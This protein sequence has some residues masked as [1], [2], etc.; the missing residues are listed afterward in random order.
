MGDIMCTPCD[1]VT[2]VWVI[3][4]AH[5]VTRSHMWVICAHHVTNI[6][7][8]PCALDSLLVQ[9]IFFD[10]EG[11][12]VPTDRQTETDRQRQTDTDTQTDRETD[13]HRQTDKDKQMEER[14]VCVRLK[15]MTLTL[16]P[17]Y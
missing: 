12:E 2:H 7:C 16:A 14:I 13:R 8:T 4:C 15:C 17:H 11:Q 6:M 3:S 10:L 9:K 5:H 1:Q